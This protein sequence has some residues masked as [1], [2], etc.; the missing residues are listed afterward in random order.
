MSGGQF[1]YIQKRIQWDVIDAIEK[2]IDNNKKEMPEEDRLCFYSKE[3]YERYPEEKLYSN[4]SDETIQEFKN[5]LEVIKKAHIY[6]QRIDWLLSGDDGE[7]SFHDRL[8]EDLDGKK[9]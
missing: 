9:N 2:V 6:I 3:H 5:G 7:D 1:G 8:K 4:Y